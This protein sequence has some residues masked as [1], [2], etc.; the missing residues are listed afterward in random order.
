MNRQKGIILSVALLLLGGGAGLLLRLQAVQR[1]GPPGIKVTAVAGTPGWR[2]ELPQGVLDYASSN[3]APAEV[4]VRMLPKDTTLGRRLYRAPDGFET[5]MS[6][7]LMG[8]DRTS[9]HKPEYCL[10]AQAWRIIKRETATIRIGGP[11]PFEMPV[12]KFIAHKTVETAPGRTTRWSGVY[13]FWFVADQRLTAS[14]L[15]RVGWITWDLM[16]KGVLPRWA[17]V[18]CFSV[19][20]AG[21]EEAAYERIE[22]FLAAAVPE[23]QLAFPPHNAGPGRKAALP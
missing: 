10:E 8:A 13:V 6:V 21:R 1:L 9:I 23:F 20:P 19:C 5:M 15:A 3:V 16:S 2:I 17:Y 18:S 4:E 7:V 14:H 12:R 22:Q 11:H